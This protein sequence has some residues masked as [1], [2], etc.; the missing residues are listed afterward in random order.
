LSEDELGLLRRDIKGGG[1]F[2]DLM[3]SLRQRSA[4][5]GTLNLTDA[6][7]EKI[8]RYAFEYGDGGFEGRLRGIFERH[9]GPRLNG[10]T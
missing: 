4:I 6:D 7:L 3:R 8:Q 2:Q 10:F 5:S 1:G 9:L